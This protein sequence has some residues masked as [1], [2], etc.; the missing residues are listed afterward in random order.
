[1]QQSN[2]CYHVVSAG[3]LTNKL[4]SARHVKISHSDL[5]KSVS[6]ADALSRWDDGCVLFGDSAP[7]GLQPVFNRNRERTRGMR[8]DRREERKIGRSIN[9]GKFWYGEQVQHAL[10][11]RRADNGELCCIRVPASYCSRY[12]LKDSAC[13]A[14][15]FESVMDSVLECLGERSPWGGNDQFRKRSRYSSEN[16]NDTPQYSWKNVELN[17]EGGGL[18]PLQF[19]PHHASQDAFSKSRPS[20]H[21]TLCEANSGRVVAQLSAF[22]VKSGHQCLF[23]IPTEVYIHAVQKVVVPDLEQTARSLLFVQADESGPAVD[24]TKIGPARDDNCF[25]VK[26]CD[27]YAKLDAR[28]GDLSSVIKGAI[29]ARSAAESKGEDVS[30]VLNIGELLHGRVSVDTMRR[31]IDYAQHYACE[32]PA[33]CC[34]SLYGSEEAAS[35]LNTFKKEQG[36]FPPNPPILASKSL[37]DTFMD[38]WSRMYIENAENKKRVFVIMLVADLMGMHSLRD[39]A[40]AHI[41]TRI[42]NETKESV[43]KS[44]REG[45]GPKRGI[46]RTKQAI[47]LQVA[48]SIKSIESRLWQYLPPCNR[49]PTLCIEVLTKSI[50]HWLR[51]KKMELVVD[52]VQATPVSFAEGGESNA[53]VKS[54]RAWGISA[55]K[56]ITFCGNRVGESD[57]I[58]LCKSEYRVFDRNMINGYSS[59]KVVDGT[60]PGKL[61]SERPTKIVYYDIEVS[62]TGNKFPQ[63]SCL[64]CQVITIAVTVRDPDGSCHN[65]TFT[66]RWLCKEGKDIAY[67]SEK[68]GRFVERAYFN[69]AYK[70]N[71]YP[72]E[73][74]MGLLCGF[75]DFLRREQP[76]AVMGWNSSG[77]DLPYLWSRTVFLSERHC[78]KKPAWNVFLTL[79]DDPACLDRE[80]EPEQKQGLSDGA[81]QQPD[82]MDAVMSESS[83]DDDSE[84]EGD[85]DNPAHQGKKWATGALHRDANTHVLVARN[86]RDL[87]FAT[88]PNSPPKNGARPRRDLLDILRVDPN[89][90]F[91]CVCNNYDSRTLRLGQLEIVFYGWVIPARHN[92]SGRVVPLPSNGN[93]PSRVHRLRFDGGSTTLLHARLLYALFSRCCR[94]EK[95]KLISNWPSAG[96]GVVEQGRMLLDR[97]LRSLEPADPS[98]RSLADRK[99]TVGYR[100]TGYVPGQPLGWSKDAATGNVS[101]RG[102]TGP[103]YCDLMLYAQNKYRPKDVGGSFALGNIVSRFVSGKEHGH[104]DTLAKMKITVQGHE[105]KSTIEIMNLLFLMPDVIPTGDKTDVLRYCGI[106]AFLVY[107]LSVSKS[108]NFVNQILTKCVI[109]GMPSIAAAV[110]SRSFAAFQMMLLSKAERM[111]FVMDVLYPL[112]KQMLK[113]P[114]ALV[115]APEIPGMPFSNMTVL[116]F[117]SMYP[118]I[119]ILF[120]LCLSTR[121][122]CSASGPEISSRRRNEWGLKAIRY[123]TKIK[124]RL[125]AEASKFEGVS[126]D[127]R[128]RLMQNVRVCDEFAR[129]IDEGRRGV[130]TMKQTSGA[131]LEIIKSNPHRIVQFLTP[132]SETECKKTGKTVSPEPMGYVT[133]SQGLIGSIL[134][135]LFYQ[136]NATK[137]K[138]KCIKKTKDCSLPEVQNEIKRLETLSLE[139]KL[140]MNSIYGNMPFHDPNILAS[141]TQL[142]R[143]WLNLLKLLC[144][145]CKKDK[146]V[147]VKFLGGDTDG[148]QITFE[149]EPPA[150]QIPSSGDECVG[151]IKSRLLRMIPKTFCPDNAL[152]ALAWV[153]GDTEWGRAALAEL[154]RRRAHPDLNPPGCAAAPASKTHPEHDHPLPGPIKAFL[155]SLDAAVCKRA[156][157]KKNWVAEEAQKLAREFNGMYRDYFCPPNDKYAI[158]RLSQRPLP[159]QPG[160]PNLEVDY[161]AVRAILVAAK[162]YLL[163]MGNKA[164]L[165]GL[166]CGKTTMCT[167]AKTLHKVFFEYMIKKQEITAWEVACAYLRGLFGGKLPLDTLTFR[168]TYNP[169]SDQTV[170]SPANTIAKHMLEKG[171]RLKKERIQ[172]AYAVKSNTQKAARAVVPTP[173]TV[174]DM[175]VVIQSIMSH[176]FGG[177]KGGSDGDLGT[178]LKAC[179][180]RYRVHLGPPGCTEAD[181]KH[182]RE[183][184]SV[185]LPGVPPTTAMRAPPGTCWVDLTEEIKWRGAIRYALVVRPSRSSRSTFEAVDDGLVS[186]DSEDSEPDCEADPVDQ[187][188]AAPLGPMVVAE[189]RGVWENNCLCAAYRWLNGDGSPGRPVSDP[190][191]TDRDRTK[192]DLALAGTPDPVACLSL[193]DMM[194]RLF[195]R[196]EDSAKKIAGDRIPY[197]VLSKHD[198]LDPFKRTLLW[199]TTK[200]TQVLRHLA[201]KQKVRESRKRSHKDQCEAR[202]SRKRARKDQCDVY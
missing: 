21:A 16:A 58:S 87:A 190:A 97:L 71:V 112:I 122:E 57:K 189:L 172:Y 81:A 99:I 199:T 200:D 159:L 18:P 127:F 111:G 66:L 82:A 6:P 195:I 174:M 22:A 166:Q 175:M 53:L 202:E 85:S 114:G 168:C 143:F 42:V 48:R 181:S 123:L 149:S 178:I 170:K 116:D 160:H 117:T 180:K 37:K 103:A 19:G 75:A 191:Y 132:L 151:I 155:D 43:A 113:L 144:E 128:K 106:D 131:L 33:N 12:T 84:G 64:A 108:F 184:G 188:S 110:Q 124:V 157:I 167:F 20:A 25:Y 69:G 17:Q 133:Q 73:T 198:S 140:G 164:K 74:E 93:N 27:G 121:A 165:C 28:V 104:A 79:F 65:H 130:K 126:E 4:A 14:A 46:R 68:S 70:T 192:I 101:V 171:T 94:Q 51:L 13:N 169:E 183:M 150:L 52:C 139:Q 161:A 148:G 60:P 31:I 119:M 11:A 2:L 196:A 107:K 197:G 156:K 47:P 125:R 63:Y 138:I 41:A 44:V 136:R 72:Y 163:D 45:W 162:R 147:L 10:F 158:T 92:A 109:Y 182:L 146:N 5:N 59:I 137:A 76:D 186:E 56:W 154:E 77:F 88:A 135:E 54:L 115:V 145:M 120:T 142:G 118:S 98:K 24:D 23:D 95:S 83:D 194:I 61:I 173:K 86:P 36:P 176:N 9:P 1:M 91:E 201:R 141:V 89:K 152:R 185:D 62:N 193:E 80:I 134:S 67:A 90:P 26:C 187:C 100:H 30:S 50:G 34:S 153:H 38:Q 3:V 7:R 179:D 32:S 39:V 8:I 49:S 102:G 78:S 177:G 96:A 129:V 105:Q 29:Q 15:L 40:C 55:G 35:A